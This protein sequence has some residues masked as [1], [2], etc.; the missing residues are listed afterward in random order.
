MSGYKILYVWLL[1]A[2]IVMPTSLCAAPSSQSAVKSPGDFERILIVGNGPERHLLEILASD[3]EQRHPTIS[4]DFFWHPNA[5]PI[6]TIELGEADIGISGEEASNGLRSLPFARDGIAIVTNF[7]N[8]VKE[9][10]TKQVAE[11]FSGKIRYWS[12]VYEEAPQTK[13]VLINRTQN[14]NIRQ[15]LEQLLNI[16]NGIPRSAVQAESEGQAIKLVSG[17]LDAVTFVSMAP[18]LRAK[19][20]GIAINLLFIGRIEPEVQTVLDGRYPLQHQVFL[21]TKPTPSPQV[22]LF[23]EFILSP[24]G[25]GLMKKGK[26]YP[27]KEQ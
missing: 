5:K 25:Q 1:L 8:P 2:G 23:E 18:A 13:I 20:D 26:Y 27:L 17:K 24:A 12:D 16:P 9:M 3:F 19:E 10:T 15:G 11:V 21:V 14:Q 6:R 7:S 22:K 4:V